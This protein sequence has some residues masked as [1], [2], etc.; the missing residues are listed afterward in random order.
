[1]ILVCLLGLREGALCVGV[2]HGFVVL[3]YRSVESIDL[4]LV[5]G[6]WLGFYCISCICVWL[7]TYVVL[8]CFGV[9]GNIVLYIGLG[10]GLFC[11]AQLS[12]C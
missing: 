7:C 3:G 1:M 11:I 6:V 2:L 8:F 12:W 5:F 9:W 4:L 10:V